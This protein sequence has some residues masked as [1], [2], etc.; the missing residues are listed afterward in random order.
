MI[1]WVGWRNKP[2]IN[3]FILRGRGLALRM[4]Q[5]LKESIF[6]RESLLIEFIELKKFRRFD[7][8]KN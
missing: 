5:V 2:G 1:H 7:K 6:A 4:K 3:S 8:G